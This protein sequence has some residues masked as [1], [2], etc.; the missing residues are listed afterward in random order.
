MTSISRILCN[1]KQVGENVLL[2]SS[3]DCYV[4][5]QVAFILSLDQALATQGEVLREAVL[6]YLDV[7]SRCVLKLSRDKA[8]IFQHS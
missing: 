5:S 7:L 3:R 2:S 8:I 4:L 1:S 6:L